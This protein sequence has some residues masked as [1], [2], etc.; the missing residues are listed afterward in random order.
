M[1]KD[2][3]E[4]GKTIYLKFLFS[5]ALF[6]IALLVF[7]FS[8]LQMI[9]SSR[10]LEER[11]MGAYLIVSDHYGFDLGNDSLRFGMI[12]PGGSSTR[13][14]IIDN[15]Y[16]QDIKVEI[17]PKQGMERFI[18]PVESVVPE[19]QTKKIGV[20]AYAPLD[21]SYGNYTGNVSVIIKRYIWKN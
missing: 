19:G 10:I 14:V 16:G 15:G 21:T 4:K 6:I 20:S 11:E 2:R 5:L 8:S 13:G 9:N 7:I 12:S 17:I 18:D 3:L 1:G